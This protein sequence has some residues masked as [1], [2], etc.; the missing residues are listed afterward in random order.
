VTVRLGEVETLEYQRDRGVGV[1]VYFGKRKGSAST[2]DLSQA[3]LADTVEKACSIAGFTAEDDCAGLPDEKQLA[4]K[5]PDLD[6]AHPWTLHPSGP[7]NWHAPV[8]PRR[9]RSTSG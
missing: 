9:S 3:A 4:L 2:S 5:F 6:L 7:S 1:T 8:N